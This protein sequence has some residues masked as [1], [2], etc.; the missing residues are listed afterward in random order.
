[1]S[2]SI[3]LLPLAAEGRGRPSHTERRGC[4]AA[5]RPCSTPT[6]RPNPNRPCDSPR[7]PETGRTSLKKRGV[8]T[9]GKRTMRGRIQDR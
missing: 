5:A 9:P 3:C 2:W 1:M 7:T 8:P 4:A 6:Y